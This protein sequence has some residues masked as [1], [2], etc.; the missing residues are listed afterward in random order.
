M[1]RQNIQSLSLAQLTAVRTGPI[2]VMNTASSVAPP[3]GDVHINVPRSD[4]QSAPPVSIPETWLPVDLCASA[5]RA[6]ILRSTSFMGAL[7]KGTIMA[8]SAED[9]QQ[10]LNLPSAGVEKARL[11]QISEAQRAALAA[12]RVGRQGTS[13]TIGDTTTSG[14]EMTEDSNRH[15]SNDG[16]AF[17][18]GK[19]EPKNGAALAPMI[20]AFEEDTLT[21]NFKAKVN[22]LFAMTESEAGNALRNMG[23]LEFDQVRYVLKVANPK[24]KRIIAWAKSTLEEQDD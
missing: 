7:Q 2:F 22:K 6:A 16:A 14:A 10:L 23:E 15:S 19:S 1:S 8:I 17:L 20:P 13:L 24:H 3:G 12:Q 11:R 5:P 4:G 21:P 18:S 9:A